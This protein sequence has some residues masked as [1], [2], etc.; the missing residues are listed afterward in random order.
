M[1]KL[2]YFDLTKRPDCLQTFI[3]EGREDGLRGRG[4][5]RKS[6][7]LQAWE[8]WRRL[9]Q[10]RKEKERYPRHP[11]SS[12]RQ[13]RNDDDCQSHSTFSALTTFVL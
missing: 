13:N 1:E 8:W 3:L 5:Q 11:T 4:R 7:R 9:A 2:S 12:Q 10:R 6:W